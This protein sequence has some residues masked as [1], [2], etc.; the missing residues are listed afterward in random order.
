MMRAGGSQTPIIAL[1]GSASYRWVINNYRFGRKLYVEYS[2]YMNKLVVCSYCCLQ[3][4]MFILNIDDHLPTTSITLRIALQASFCTELGL[5]DRFVSVYDFARYRLHLP[6]NI[7]CQ[8][9]IM[10]YVWSGLGRV[11]YHNLLYHGDS[12]VLRHCAHLLHYF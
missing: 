3:V 2:A 9:C 7:K 11:C 12:S 4:F 1:W 6:F 10:F 8:I 5:H